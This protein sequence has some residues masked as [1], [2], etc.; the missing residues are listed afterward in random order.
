MKQLAIGI[1][2]IGTAALLTACAAADDKTAQAPRE[3]KTVTTGSNIPKRDK[4]DANVQTVSPAALERAA[5]TGS[6]PPA[7]R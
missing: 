4:G 7:A 5:A 6:A 3:E 2:S 1:A